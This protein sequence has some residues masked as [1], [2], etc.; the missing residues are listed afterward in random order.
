M[1]SRRWP[2]RRRRS[3]APAL[4]RTRREALATFDQEHQITS[5]LQAAEAR[6]ANGE[7]LV[8]EAAAAEQ[9]TA[10]SLA[11]VDAT[12]AAAAATEQQALA[13]MEAV[14]RASLVDDMDWQLLARLASL[15]SVGL[16]GSV[17]LVLD[18]PFSV[19]DDD[20]LMGVLDRLARLADAVQIVLVTDREAAV[21][22]A[23][24]A[25][26]DRALV[27]SS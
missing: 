20:E 2:R 4:A 15:R 25:G 10:A 12:F 3:L 23:A 19:L 7:R 21:A 9:T 13:E 11:E 6:V 26:S 17:P 1:R 18:D 14:D 24:Q 5:L 16:A 8:T 27:I 22:W